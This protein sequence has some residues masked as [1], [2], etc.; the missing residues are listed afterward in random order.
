MI[1]LDYQMTNV[2]KKLKQ[3]F[4]I[5]MELGLTHSH[6]GIYENITLYIQDKRF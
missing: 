6:I 4:L 2:N 5:V 3:I 1:I